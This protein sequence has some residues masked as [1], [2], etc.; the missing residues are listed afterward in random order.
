MLYAKQDVPLQ[1][2]KAESVVGRPI[3]ESFNGVGQVRANCMFLVTLLIDKRRSGSTVK[4]LALLSILLKL[5]AAL[6]Q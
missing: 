2:R 5:D 3:T 1:W 4:R 6:S